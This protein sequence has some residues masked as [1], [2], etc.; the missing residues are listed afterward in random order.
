MAPDSLS[1]S[2]SAY[3]TMFVIFFI[4]GGSDLT[5]I[6]EQL[7][8]DCVTKFDYVFSENGLA[9]FKVRIHIYIYICAILRIDTDIHSLYIYTCDAV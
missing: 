8:E 6:K 1:L 3:Y 4:V 7:G 9:A 2:L 5:K